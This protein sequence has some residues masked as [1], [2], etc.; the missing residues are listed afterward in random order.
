M[1]RI[2]T[3]SSHLSGSCLDAVDTLA[4]F[5]PGILMQGTVRATSSD[6]ENRHGAVRN[7]R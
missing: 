4:P 2:L 1:R 5:Y 7:N 3:L 6:R